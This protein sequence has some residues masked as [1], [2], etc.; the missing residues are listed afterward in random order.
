MRSTRRSSRRST[1]KRS[2]RRQKGGA[3]LTTGNLS[4]QN[5]K[6]VYN[7]RK[8]M[9]QKELNQLKTGIVKKQQAPLV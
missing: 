9:I 3:T 1:R 6:A 5:L 7:L 2:T 8:N 4:I